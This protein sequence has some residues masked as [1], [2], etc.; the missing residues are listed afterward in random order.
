MKKVE[1]KIL[2]R[3]HY[4]G[5]LVTKPQGKTNFQRWEEQKEK[6]SKLELKAEEQAQ[7]IKKLTEEIKAL[8]PEKENETPARKNAKSPAEKYREL[9]AKAKKELEKA[10]ELRDAISREV[11]ECAKLEGFKNKIE[12]SNTCKKRLKTIAIELRY[13]RRK[14][15]QN[16]YFKKGLEHEDEGAELYS[17]YLGE[18]LVVEKER[19][20][21]DYFTGETDLRKRN[22]EGEVIEITDVKNRFDLDTFEDNRGEEIAHAHKWQGFGYA[23]L[24]P[25]AKVFKVCNVLCDLNLTLTD[26]EIRRETYNTK[27]EDLTATGSLKNARLIEIVKEHIYSRENFIKC[28]SLHIE[29]DELLKLNKGESADEEAQKM[30]NEF[31]ELD[32]DERIIE[33]KIEITEE[34]RA[35]IENAKKILDACRDYL[36]EVYNIHHIEG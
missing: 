11:F 7:K 9:Q 19:I 17:E 27:A 32:L 8:E 36:R 34:V 28:L 35:E 5:E 21:N 30:F 15:L 22:K 1:A 6:V 2:F 23:D 14:R 16:K 29:E 20:K 26:D 13:K 4:L 33:Q 3:P 12:L 18:H 10:E 25:T 31:I 24:Y